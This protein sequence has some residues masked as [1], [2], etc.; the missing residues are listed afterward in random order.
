MQNP[1]NAF[2]GRNQCVECI[3]FVS[4]ASMDLKRMGHL[5]ALADT[6]HF[7]RAAERCHLS[8]PAFSRSVL[9]A[10]DALGLQLFNRGT[11]E[12]TCTDAG[13]FV[14]ERARRLLFE[15][16][17]LERDVAMY[18][19]R[20]IGDIAF[21]M[22]PYPAATLLLALLC[23]LRNN[24]PGINTRVE[25]NNTQ[26]LTEHLRNESLDFFVADMRNLLPHADLLVT[27]LGEL[28]AAFYVGAGHPLCGKTVPLASVL[29]YGLASVQVP[30]SLLLALGQVAGLPQGA[31]LPQ[32]LTC[33]DV[34]VLKGVAMATHTV[35]ACPVAGA[36]RE[37]DSGA[38]V[39]LTLTDVPPVSAQMGVVSLRG[40]SFSSM[41]EFAIGFLGALAKRHALA[42]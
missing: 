7:G 24:Y 25:V 22:G 6:R 40:R 17:C 26:Y 21:G 8:Q 19:E 28:Q 23:E 18:R 42:P 4:G 16:R 1:S 9:A 14:V 33:D 15:S 30:E 41:A 10:E 38:L 13:A 3:E 35:I 27:P 12:I 29:P 5:V 39:P 32:V 34:Q 11:L 37:V 36:I 31:L 2:C 20:Q